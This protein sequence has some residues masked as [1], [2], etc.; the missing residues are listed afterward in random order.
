MGSEQIALG[1]KMEGRWLIEDG[2]LGVGVDFGKERF[3]DPEFVELFGA[4]NAADARFAIAQGGP[5]G[6]LDGLAVGGK[7]K[8]QGAF[9]GVHRA[10]FGRS[11]KVYVSGCRVIFFQ[12]S[13][14]SEIGEADAEAVTK[15]TF[16]EGQ[17]NNA[18]IIWFARAAFET[19][20]ADD[21]EIHARA[22]D[23]FAVL[24]HDEEV[25]LVERDAGG[26]RH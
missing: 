9:A 1:I 7:R 24:V 15:R 22:G 2:K 6:D 20:F 11:E 8:R 17:G 23:V 12:K 5:E 13:L 14:S 21:I 18:E 16:G 4:L 26:V 3:G 10:R 19:P 25:E